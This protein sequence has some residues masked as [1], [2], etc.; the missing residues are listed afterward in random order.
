MLSFEEICF[1]CCPPKHL[2]FLSIKKQNDSFSFVF[3]I[4]TMNQ[5]QVIKNT[6]YKCYAKLSL[7]NLH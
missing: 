6:V 7:K 5:K 2:V 3:T 4:L 1:N